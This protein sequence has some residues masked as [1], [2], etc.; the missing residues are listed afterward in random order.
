MIDGRG[1]WH[2]VNNEIIS[3]FEL[4]LHAERFAD[5]LLA[6]GYSV[7]AIEDGETNIEVT[8]MWPGAPMAFSLA[9]MSGSLSLNIRKGQF[10][11]I[12]P[13][14]GRLFGLLSIQALPRRLSLDFADLFKKGLAFDQIS[15]MF[16]IQDGHAYTNDLLMEGLASKVAIS[17]RTGLVDQDYDQ[18]VT[19]TP[20]ISDSLPLASALFGPAGIGIGAIILIAGQ[21][22]E[23]IPEQI[24]K[25]LSFQYTMTGSWEDPVIEPYKP[26]ERETSQQE[27]GRIR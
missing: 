15:G 7:I 2:A 1:D 4:E 22:F 16:E 19:V 24:D 8:A 27:L 5:M 12:D 3:D 21:V 6:F 11:D 25:L 9:D 10:L 17:G 18:I 13:R 23:A 20:H 26:R 14:A